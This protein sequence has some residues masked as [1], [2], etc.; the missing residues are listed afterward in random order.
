MPNTCYQ[1]IPFKWAPCI[2]SVLQRAFDHAN[3][4]QALKKELELYELVL[5]LKF[6]TT[7]QETVAKIESFRS[8]L[9]SLKL[10][11]DINK[12]AYDLQER[13]NNDMYE[14]LM[15][16][17]GDAAYIKM[18]YTNEGI[19][20]PEKKKAFRSRNRKNKIKN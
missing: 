3:M 7:D 4:L 15:A 14:R 20:K 10:K 1:A 6:T 11:K 5:L 8:D 9:K 16:F 17:A 19:R 18:I 2:L 13:R 12:I